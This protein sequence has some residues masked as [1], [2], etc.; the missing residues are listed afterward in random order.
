MMQA[1]V[2]PISLVLVVIVGLG[3]TTKSGSPTDVAASDDRPTKSPDR[4]VLSWAQ[5]PASSLS[6]TWRTDTTVTDAR[7]QIA[8]AESAPSFYKDAHNFHANTTQLDPAAAA[9]AHYHSVTFEDL[10]PDTLYAYRVGDGTH[11]SEWF[12]ARTAASEPEPF[13]YIYF[14]DAQ[15]NLKSHWSRV[16]RAAFRKAPDASFMIHAGDLVNQAHRD[17]EWGYWNRAGGWVQGMLPNVPVPGNHEYAPHPEH[18]GSRHL[19]THWRPQ[20]TLPRNGPDGLKETVYALDHQGMRIIG[21]NTQIAKQDDRWLDRQTEWLTS[22]LDTTDTRWT[23][24]TMHHPIFSSADGRD[25]E[26]IRAAWR[27]LFEKHRVD[28]VMQGHDHTYSRGQTQNLSQGV[29]ARAP[30]GGTVYVNSVSGAK[31]YQIK[32]DRWG[33]YEGIDLERGGENTQLFQVVHV[34]RDTLAYRSYT[35]TGRPYD[36][37]DLVKRPDGRLNEL[38]ERPPSDAAER[39]WEN[40][41]PYDRPDGM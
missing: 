15:N 31:M 24:V 14:G 36:A 13:S 38:I 41:P 3:C 19:S 28:L 18:G 17:L 1:S 30:T 26:A 8:L 34:S 4:V 10:S 32:E 6:V 7:A 27:P 21:L 5:D 9:A 25:N 37:F 23:V 35:A 39:T 22:V 40:T 12:H 2:R 29:N 16:I 20:F 33:A 11:W